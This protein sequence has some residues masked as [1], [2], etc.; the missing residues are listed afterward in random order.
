[1]PIVSSLGL[2]KM[3]SELCYNQK[4]ISL[5]QIARFEVASYCRPRSMALQSGMS[6][7]TGW[8][9]P[10]LRRRTMLRLPSR[11]Q[12]STWTG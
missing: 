12:L 1:M 5:Q 2:Y 8:Q 9:M 10:R 6:A 7:R 3:T 4:L 11:G